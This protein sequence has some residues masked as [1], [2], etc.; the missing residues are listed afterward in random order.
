MRELRPSISEAIDAYLDDLALAGKTRTTLRVYRSHLQLPDWP[1]SV[2]LR[3]M[4]RQRVQLRSLKTAADTHQILKG[5]CAYAVSMGWLVENP[6]LAIPK[7]KP[8][9]PPH[10]YLTRDQVRAVYLAC[11]SDE[12]RLIVRLLLLGLRANEL[13][14][15]RWDQV[16]DVL[17]VE[18][19]KGGRHRLLPLDA[20]TLALLSAHPRTSEYVIPCTYERLA[21]RVRSLGA[22]AG[23]PWLRCHD[24]RR[25]MATNW[26]LETNDPMTLQ[27]LGGW[28]GT[29]MVQRYAKSALEASAVSKARAVNLTGK[30][31]GL[32][33]EAGEVWKTDPLPSQ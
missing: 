19:G 13:L 15:V 29:A 14:G 9:A 24:W 16:S 21:R 3:D 17:R 26:L 7:P 32:K 27:Q 18:Y 6:M 1:T 10:R 23:V 2:T 11:A 12:E 31:L 30:L 20:D 8:K 25:T 28:A 5:F 4:M 22:K 33:T